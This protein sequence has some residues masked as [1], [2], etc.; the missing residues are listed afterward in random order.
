MASSPLNAVVQ[1]LRAAAQRDGSR[2]T[3]KELLTSYLSRRDDD[4]LAALVER[5]APMVWGVCRRILRHH[6]DAED[7]FQATFIVL[8]RKAATIIPR[9]MVANW[10]YGVARQS[11]V[12]LRAVA[13][14]RGA[15]EMQTTEM[16][17]LAAAAARDTELLSLLDHELSRLPERFRVLIVLCDLEGKSR[18]EAARQL[19][20]PEGTVAS[21]LARAREMLAKRLTHRGVALSG[22]AMAALLSQ[23]AASAGVPS[24]VVVSTIK[25]ATLVAAGK[26]ATA[27]AISAQVSALTEGVMKAMLLTKLKSAIAVALTIGFVAIGTTIV[28]CRTAEGQAGEKPPAE[29]PVQPLAKQEQEAF[30]A[31]GKEAGGLQAGLGF[32]P[33]EKRAYRHGEAVT[34]VVRVRNVGKET[35]KFEYVK[36]FLDE[37]PPTVTGAD[38]K[39]VLQGGLTVL[40]QHHVTV[41]VSLAP[42]KEIELESRIPGAAGRRYELMPPGGGGKRATEESPLF[43]GTGKVSLQYERVIGNSSASSMKMDPALSKLATGTLELE[44]EPVPP[45]ADPKPAKDG[46]PAADAAK[47]ALEPFQGTWQIAEA[48]ERGKP[49]DVGALK[50]HPVVFD[51]DQWEMIYEGDKTMKWTVTVRPDKKPAEIDAA[52]PKDAGKGKV[53]RGIYKFEDGALTIALGLDKDSTRPTKFESADGDKPTL[54][55]ALKKSI[56][57]MATVTVRNNGTSIIYNGAQGT[58]FQGVAIATFG[59]GQIE[60][61]VGKDEWE[62]TLKVD[63]IMVRFPRPYGLAVQITGGDKTY[64][65]SEFIIPTA[66]SAASPIA[67]VGD[68]YVSFGKWDPRILLL[69]RDRLGIGQPENPR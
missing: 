1:Q 43:V 68:A 28:A 49:G 5:H 45:A 63:H 56:T 7:A 6:H 18:K 54:V 61:K 19:N 4:A 33:G 15:R 60:F 12:R 58:V 47:K 32:P 50:K 42:G 37:K 46:A 38:G 55:L 10:L 23:Q 34:L 64:E 48:N 51:G 44:I 24:A 21:R 52:F 41:E 26:A 17:D 8:V 62:A 59:T 16:P 67:R 2:K 30:T 13:A 29:K 65:V 27:G 57:N 39:T 20:C 3:D 25:A 53:G 11:A 31:W 35:V 69:L 22:G 66:V 40:T 9:E 36:Q 14:K